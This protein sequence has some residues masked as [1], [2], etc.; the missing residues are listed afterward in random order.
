MVM[1]IVWLGLVCL[2]VP[3]IAQYAGLKKKTEKGLGWIAIAGLMFILAGA[4][5]ATTVT[6]WATSDLTSVA[7][8]GMYLFQIIGWIFVLVGVLSAAFEYFKK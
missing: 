8:G 3:A 1:E 2:L 5:D 4:F 6:F 7:D